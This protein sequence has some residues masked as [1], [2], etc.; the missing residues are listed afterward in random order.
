V[1]GLSGKEEMKKGSK[2]VELQKMGKW[3]EDKGFELGKPFDTY[4][5]LRRQFC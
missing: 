3:A 1:P 2:D 5:A 4:R